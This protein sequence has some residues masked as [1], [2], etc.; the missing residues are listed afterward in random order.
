MGESL[1][2][3]LWPTVFEELPAQSVID[4]LSPSIQ[5]LVETHFTY[6]ISRIPY[7]LS[8][9]LA[10]IMRGEVFGPEEQL[11]KALCSS[12][13]QKRDQL[14]R[15]DSNCMD[16]LL[17]GLT[18]FG[19]VDSYNFNFAHEIA[20]FALVLESKPVDLD[21]KLTIFL[22]QFFNY[23]KK[24]MHSGGFVDESVL[25]L[26]FVHQHWHLLLGHQGS[27][28]LPMWFRRRMSQKRE[29]PSGI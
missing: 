17:L 26:S 19:L 15:Y 10:G 16:R 7:L 1:P 23:I 22:G 18:H 28:L 9:A 21:H 8:T 12:A 4:S 29:F 5:R 25:F 27:L 2:A 6:L 13:V 11:F 14:T 3:L 20:A 24:S